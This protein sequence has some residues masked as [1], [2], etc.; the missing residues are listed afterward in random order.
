MRA[1]PVRF[2]LHQTAEEDAIF[3]AKQ[4]RHDVELDAEIKQKRDAI[5]KARFEVTAPPPP[6]SP[7]LY[8]TVMLVALAP[9]ARAAD[10]RPRPRQQSFDGA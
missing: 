9:L 1:D 7:S 6:S 8:L 2:A 4:Q 10:G 3:D 5:A